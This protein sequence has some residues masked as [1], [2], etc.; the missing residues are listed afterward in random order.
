MGKAGNGGTLGKFRRAVYRA[1]HNIGAAF[2]VTGIFVI[3]QE[4]VSRMPESLVW[5]MSFAFLMVVFGLYLLG[6]RRELRVISDAA[7][8]VVET[9]A[10]VGKTT[11][12]AEKAIGKIAEP[13]KEKKK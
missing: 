6:L 1:R 4:I 2:F 10:S 7:D 11:K 5:R 3:A 9:A 13:P 8:T 12:K